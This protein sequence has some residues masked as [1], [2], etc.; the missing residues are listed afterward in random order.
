MFELALEAVR[1][2]RSGPQASRL[3]IRAF[4]TDR[5]WEKFH[6]PF[7]I[8]LALAGEAGK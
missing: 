8:A 6:T 3:A 2:P 5:E 1:A 4:C 7:N